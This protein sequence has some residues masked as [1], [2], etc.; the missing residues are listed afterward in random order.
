MVPK[1]S[2][3]AREQ[4]ERLGVDV[5]TG[6]KVVGIDADGVTYETRDGEAV[7]THRLAARTL[8]WA[9]GVAASPLGRALRTQ[10][11]RQA[12]PRGPSHRRAGPVR[13]PAIPRSASSAISPPR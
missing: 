2:Q 9:A 4:I 1:L 12:R 6:S 13:S 8:V 3:R 10:R 11:R 5:R 7:H